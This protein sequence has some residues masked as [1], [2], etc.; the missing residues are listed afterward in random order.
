MNTETL[1]TLF[2]K[3]KT[4]S[5]D[6]RSIPKNALFFGIK[7]ENFNGNQ[8]ASKAIEQGALYAIVD[9]KEFEDENNH[10]FWVENSIKAL[11]DLANYHRRELNVPILA[12]TGSNGKTT[13]K[14]L[15]TKVLS[16]KYKVAATKGNFNNHLGVP[17]TLLSMKYSDEIGIVEMGANHQKEIELL[18]RIAE[19]D[20]GYITNFGK[21]HL[22]GFGGIEGVIKG[23]SEL[24]QYL[25]DNE[26]KAFINSDDPI[27]I[28][29]GH[30][31][32]SLTFGTKENSQFKF[33]YSESN[34]GK[35]PEI[36]YKEDIFKSEL[37]GK[38]NVS[39]VA[40]AVAI[41]LYF[42][43]K[44]EKIKS[45]IEEYTSGE[46]R[47]QILSTENH[48]IILDAYNANPSSMEEAIQN[49]SFINGSKALVLG[50]MFE[51]GNESEFEHQR[52]GNLAYE[53]EFSSVYLIG[54][55]FNKIQI[56][57]NKNIHLFQDR[58]S[59]EAFLKSNPIKEKHI[60]IKGSR[61]MALEKLLDVI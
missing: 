1:Y 49:F 37:I 59:A 25:K 32:K 57:Q 24:F 22:E 21:A 23:K 41:G 12:L 27:Q 14:E 28:K 40:A 39:N 20:F 45:A 55:S 56:P 34:N 33:T 46:N 43:V 6:T 29:L 3:C 30:D 18:C 9:E 11:Q 58:N 13:T 61:G 42:K 36:Q 38:Y 52:I 19:P 17:L 8:F 44:I 7:G 51:L 50:D 15:I 2:Q 48:E 4:L 35:C 16:Q 26:K 5:I 54:N 53:N 10:I 31:L 47:S 60:L